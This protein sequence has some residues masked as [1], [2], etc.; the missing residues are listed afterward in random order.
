MGARPRTA[1]AINVVLGLPSLAD[2]L[3]GNRPYLGAL[4]GRYANRIAERLA[5]PS[6]ASPTGSRPTTART[7]CTVA[8]RAST[9][10]SWRAVRSHSSA[11]GVSLVLRYASPDGEEGFPGALVVEATVTVFRDHTLR[12]DFRAATDRPTVVNLTSH[13]YWNLAGEGTGAALDQVLSLPASR[14]LPVGAG[15]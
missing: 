8:G 9:G 3:A 15:R 13:A 12:L 14:Y 7:A 5:S 10:G 4:I 11:D 6:T 2:Y 1:S